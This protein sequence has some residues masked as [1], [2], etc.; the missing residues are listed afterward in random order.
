MVYISFDCAYKTLGWCIFDINEDFL[1]DY[2][3]NGILSFIRWYDGG[4]EDLLPNCSVTSCSKEYKTKVLRDFLLSL[5]IS[6]YDNITIIVEEQP[7]NLSF[8]SS[9]V[10][11]QI[12]MYYLTLY[13]CE[14]VT[15]SPAGK[16]K[17]QYN[18]DEEYNLQHLVQHYKSLGIKKYRQKAVKQHSVNNFLYFC[19]IFNIV[20]NMKKSKLEH[21]ADS[22][23]QALVWILLNK[24]L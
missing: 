13:D 18:N 14:I 2:N 19:D 1:D 4:V 20:I 8:K 11:D 15:V 17:I 7:R 12:C 5:D 22:F 24:I 6:Q 23:Q 9:T 21:I 16:T 3:N 10:E